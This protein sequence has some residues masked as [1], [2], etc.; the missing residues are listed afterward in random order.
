M[1]FGKLPFISLAAAVIISGCA[2][3]SP[4]DGVPAGL[5][6]GSKS[7][8]SN[9]PSAAASVPMTGKQFQPHELGLQLFQYFRA[10]PAVNLILGADAGIT[11]EE[12]SAFAIQQIRDENPAAFDF[13]KGVARQEFDAVCEK[14]FGRV[15]KN[16]DNPKIRTLPSGN[17]TPTGWSMSPH[18]LVLKEYAE[19]PDGRYSAAFYQVHMAMGEE[20]RPPDVV[21]G[22]LLE[23]LS[24]GR[25]QDYEE[26]RIE[27]E[28][29][30]PG[31]GQMYLRY[32]DVRDPGEGVFQE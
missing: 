31:A 21:Y 6:A 26:I 9:S 18:D 27:F 10:N 19:Q 1:K 28:I 16:A 2:A 14:H 24:N 30:N 5:T 8:A 23:D 17:I 4:A 11:D 25:V 20:T 3:S 12:I 22:A 15:L 13:E 29:K 7:G 32:Y